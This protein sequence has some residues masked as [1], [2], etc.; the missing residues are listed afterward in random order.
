MGMFRTYDHGEELFEQNHID[1]YIQN[2]SYI[3]RTLLTYTKLLE[4]LTVAV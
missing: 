4:A 3:E 1:E 2:G